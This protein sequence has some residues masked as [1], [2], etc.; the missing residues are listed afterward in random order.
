[1][2]AKDFLCYEH[3]SAAF[4]ED[5]ESGYNKLLRIEDVM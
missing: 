1:M 4:Y 5:E 2:L 3:P